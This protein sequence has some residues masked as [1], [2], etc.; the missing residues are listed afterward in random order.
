MHLHGIAAQLESRRNQGRHYSPGTRTMGEHQLCR[1]YVGL[2]G[3]LADDPAMLVPVAEVQRA[4]LIDVDAFGQFP[5]LFGHLPL[6]EAR[7]S[8]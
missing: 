6:H 8:A 1:V 2:V 7:G 5:M 3:I 4:R